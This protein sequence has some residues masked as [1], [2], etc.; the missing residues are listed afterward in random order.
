SGRSRPAR[1]GPKRRSRCLCPARDRGRRSGWFHRMLF[2]RAW[3]LLLSA[4]VRDAPRRSATCEVL[5]LALEHSDLLAQ[6]FLLGFVVV[7]AGREVVVVLPPIQADLLRLVDG[8]DDESDAD[9]EE[10][11]FRERHLDV[12]R[13]DQTLVEHAVEDVDEAARLM[14]SEL[15]VRGHERSFVDRPP[16]SRARGGM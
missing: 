14:S 13:D 11:D 6:C 8:A 5:E 7:A 2:R 3:A 10:L 15:Q 4:A 16:G 1:P 9:G 12:A